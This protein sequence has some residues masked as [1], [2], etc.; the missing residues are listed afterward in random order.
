[1]E[2]REKKKNTIAE[3]GS[4]E[5]RSTII[6]RDNKTES[7]QKGKGGRKHS[8]EQQRKKRREDD[9]KFH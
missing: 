6:R 5:W 7:G 1:M 8:S 3:R 9:K 4:K 2:Q